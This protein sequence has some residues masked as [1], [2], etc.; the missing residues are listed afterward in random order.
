MATAREVAEAYI[1]VNGDMRRFRDAVR[2]Q[3]RDIADKAGEDLGKR[4]NKS[5]GDELKKGDSFKSLADSASFKDLERDFQSLAKATRTKD[6]DQF[7]RRFNSNTELSRRRV[8]AVTSEMQKFGRI[9][10]Q[11]VNRVI[12]SFDQFIDR[13]KQATNFDNAQFRNRIKE[14][15]R[16][17][18]EFASLSDHK[19]FERF[20]RRFGDDSSA[21]RKRVTEVTREMVKNNRM[22][23]AQSK[24]LR[25]MA[26]EYDNGLKAAERA[27]IASEQARAAAKKEE[28]ANRKA[29]KARLAAKREEE[30]QARRIAAE[31]EK[32][33]KAAERQA[34]RNRRLYKSFE[35]LQ[36][37]TAVKDLEKDFERLARASRDGNFRT[38]FRSMES[39]A[40]KARARISE[41][42]DEMVK[43]G[44]MS[45][46]SRVRVK[47]MFEEFDKGNRTI[48]GLQKNYQR[49]IS[50]G[51]KGLASLSRSWRGLDSTVRLVLGLIAISAGQI[52][53]ILSALA[54]TAVSVVSSVGMAL[55]AIIPL[56][57]VAV[58]AALSIGL[59]TSAMEDMR[60]QFPA[61]ES[62]I[63]RIKNSWQDLTAAF[64]AEAGPGLGRM[65]NALADQM[66]RF[67]FGT[68]MG[69]A[70]GGISD[71]FA[72]A[73]TSPGVTAF[74]RSL[75]QEYPRAFES[76]GRGAANVFSA[77]GSLMAG[78]A[79]LAER[80]GSMFE[81]WSEG[82]AN[83]AERA[84]ESGAMSEIFDRVGD[85]VSAV[86]NVIGSLGRA[87]GAVFM[88]TSGHGNDLLNSFA[89]MIDRF[90][91]WV[92]SAEGQKR[93]N[94]WLDTGNKLLG[95]MGD[96]VGGV[97]TALAKM[98]TPDTI[99]KA[100]DFLTIMG[101]WLPKLAD[102]LLAVNELDILGN[103]ARLLNMV[104]DAIRPLMPHLTNMADV[105]GNSV[106]GAIENASPLFESLA[107]AFEPLLKRF[108]EFMQDV[109]PQFVDAVGRISES[110][111]PVIDAFGRVADFIQSILLPIFQW[112]VE[113]IIA[114][115]V[116]AFEG[117]GKMVGGVVD[118]VSSLIEGDWRGAWNALGDI[119]SGV[120]QLVWGVLQVWIIG[121][122][123]GIIRTLA[124]GAVRLIS[125]GWNGLVNITQTVWTSIWTFIQTA[126]T[127]ILGVIT[128]VGTAIWGFVSGAWENIRAV[129][130]TVWT[131]ISDAISFAWEWITTTV[132]TVLASVIAFI[133]TG[134]ETVSS[135]TSAVWE[136]IS[137]FFSSV[138]EGISAVV[139][140]A[141]TFI[142]TIIS[143]IWTAIT[144][145]IS[146][147]LSNI[148]TIFSTI[149]TA[150][151]TVVSNNV[152]NIRS[153]ISTVW[154][155]IKS[156]ISTTMNAIRTTFS[157]IWNAIKSVISSV[158][159]GIRS[160]I[161]S[162]WNGI[163]S[164]ISNTMNAIRNTFSRIWAAIKTVI[165]NNVNNIR[166]TISSVWNG[167]KSFISSVMNGIRNT[168]STIWNA[169]RN[170]ISNVVN[171]IRSVI[172][173]VWNGIRNIISSV[174]NSIRN[175]ISSIWNAIRN[176]ISSVVNGIRNAVSIGFNG[177]RNAGVNAFNSMR[178]AVS[179][180]INGLLNSVRTAANGIKNAFSNIV[181][182]MRTIGRNIIQGVINGVGSMGGMLANA[183]R[184]VAKGA[185]NAIKG[186]FGIKSPSR[187]MRKVGV[188][189]GEGLNLGLGDEEKEVAKGMEQLGEAALSGMDVRKYMN[190]GADAAE[191]FA[192]GLSSVDL[193]GI[194]EPKLNDLS[195]RAGVQPVGTG[196]PREEDLRY[197]RAGGTTIEEGAIQVSTPAQDGKI[198]AKQMV[199][200]LVRTL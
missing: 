59:M 97:G 105:I 87:I 47:L 25:D 88:A 132:Q 68:P 41:V 139:Q 6:F 46:D 31:H 76:F 166:S 192:N 102:V 98:V 120:I 180:T 75:T 150:I 145:F 69:R 36:K 133:I 141:I 99:Q 100:G 23:E 3:G 151:K 86:M 176:I 93:I 185:M 178:N 174:M 198:V 7:F 169:I 131:A 37:V 181:G 1:Q 130:E 106:A 109:G 44:R 140:G 45:D 191:A 167:I 128:A 127:G 67:D 116:D 77:L 40:G 170:T 135:T 200:E 20:W 157:T 168:F 21:A 173:S 43:M 58:T 148:Q 66:A 38:F 9:T 155:G 13:Q 61:V 161:S 184:N 177:A 136:G 62:G 35:E 187:E 51:Q 63:Q 73:L 159:N 147:T 50:I 18:Q 123:M 164:F 114:G 65:L 82:L 24:A 115:V 92:K 33:R 126:W 32:A 89:K 175:T 85:S 55:G 56:A 103:L 72:S 193:T 104:S 138:W 54:S 78:A 149:W 11:E 108:S 101:E 48:R 4:F 162:V 182:S 125:T 29:E 197:Q 189:I 96:L 15:E 110:L 64:A 91:A 107:K 28:E 74:F 118:L 14:M 117:L 134:W 83:A 42:T 199:D 8:L 12:K 144:T 10:P 153:V 124:T 146:T 95:P 113:G 79:P 19:G 17:F 179:N 165:T 171:G 5:F 195:R 143:T 111:G 2:T 121:K 190:A 122:I 39:D 34:E 152:N 90:T 112:L 188:W 156:F 94:E 137:T 16:D 71:A 196:R 183:A 60:A 30:A 84:R 49:F 81:R 53:S 129:T 52:A 160:T 70:M 194:L 172:T 119:V 186:I 154:N 142:Q 163:K 26:R 80:L 57:G 22:T 27:R 158:V